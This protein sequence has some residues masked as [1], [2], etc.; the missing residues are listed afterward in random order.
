M[1]D[2]REITSLVA[3]ILT[4]DGAR[5][6]TAH[7]GRDAMVF[8]GSG[9]FDLLILDL[10]MPRPDG[11]D[12]LEFTGKTIP[13]MLARTIVLTGMG[14][15]RQAVKAL[16]DRGVMHLFKPFQIDSLRQIVCDLLSV[17]EPTWAA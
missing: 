2:S 15:S 6:C 1:D 8:L 12:V 4:T 3:D 11:W 14:Y 13:R 16:Q 10:A 5:V 17:A 7:N 9:K